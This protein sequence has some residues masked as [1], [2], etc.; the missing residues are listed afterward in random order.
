MSQTGEGSYRAPAPVQT[1][2]I[3]LWV[4][5]GGATGGLWVAGYDLGWRGPVRLTSWR[6]K[7]SYR[8]GFAP[9]EIGVL[10][11]RGL[12]IWPG[13]Q[14]TLEGLTPGASSNTPGWGRCSTHFKLFTSWW[15]Q[16]N[17]W[18]G[19]VRLQSALLFLSSPT[20][21]ER[22]LYFG[23]YKPSSVINSMPTDQRLTLT[24]I[25]GRLNGWRLWAQGPRG[26]PYSWSM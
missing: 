25:S 17:S 21:Q 8:S 4:R 18:G 14:Y 26:F 23:S 24:M 1:R 11:R 10:Q 9:Q 16:H 20:L 12:S 2:G 22:L 15:L 5:W 7:K 6:W 13:P 3:V 19:G